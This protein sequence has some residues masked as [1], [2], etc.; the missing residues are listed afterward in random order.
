[1][2]VPALVSWISLAAAGGDPPWTQSPARKDVV[3]ARLQSGIDRHGSTRVIVG[4]AMAFEPGRALPD[5][6]AAGRRQSIAER[7]DA[8]MAAL[9]G[10]NA[11]ELRRFRHIPFLLLEV[12]GPALGALLNLPEVASLSEDAAEPP[13]LNS[14]VPVIG[15]DVAWASGYDGNGWTVAV[16][17]TGVDKTH[18]FFAAE[19]KVVSEACYSTNA[20]DTVSLCPEQAPS[21]TEPGSGVNCPVEI[22]GCDHGT[23]VA[24]IASGKD[25]VGNH[26]GVARG[27]RII[28]I[29]VFSYQEGNIH[30]RD[31]GRSCLN[32]FVSDQ[33]AALE[34]IYD[35]RDDFPIA[36]VNMSLGGGKYSDVESCDQE[37]TENG[38]K[39]AVD[40][41]RTA[42]IPVIA[43][44]GNISWK[45]SIMTPACISTV[46]SVGATTDADEL[47][48]FSNVAGFLDLLA[49]GVDIDSAVPGGGVASKSG[50]SMATPHVAGAW[51]V[52]KQFRPQS[53]IEAVLG[54]LR[55]SGTSIDDERASGSVTD[56]RRINVDQAIEYL[57]A[58]H[59][60]FTSDPP[61]GSLIDFGELEVGSSSVPRVVAVG[62]QGEADL[63][64]TCSISGE[65]AT[66]FEILSC[67]A[68]LPAGADGLIELRCLPSRVGDKAA[69]LGLQTSDPAE[70][71]PA[72]PLFCRVAPDTVFGD[73]FE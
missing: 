62:N 49:P 37:Q 35:L 41:L 52:L 46:V 12:D 70:P 11:T 32:A 4:L 60:V 18:P 36:A 53:S 14:S 66:A 33:I 42:G 19:G 30:C 44:S 54:A 67:P 57:D 16:L 40:L 7:Q 26:D 6:M 55:V 24:G 68:L 20:D 22:A 45:D 63:T 9:A 47:A 50:T 34:R 73:G 69:L 56:L 27:A 64:V 29:Q 10:R 71:E 58:P 48:T 1:L 28:S 61:A 38:R 59:P 31:S 21:S 17:D 43:A 13:T 15:A 25:P 65:A 39:P 72:F 3:V 23:H 8:L 2:L 5:A 51:A